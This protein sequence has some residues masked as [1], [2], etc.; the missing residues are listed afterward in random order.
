MASR[1]V[2]VLI[3]MPLRGFRYELHIVEFE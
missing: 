2:P 3:E 1:P